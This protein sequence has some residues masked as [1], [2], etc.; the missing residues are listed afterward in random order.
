M[1]LMILIVNK[2][3]SRRRTKTLVI[4]FFRS[5]MN[6]QNRIV[7]RI[8][9]IYAGNFALKTLY[10]EIRGTNNK[11]LCNYFLELVLSNASFKPFANFSGLSTA[12]K[13]IMNSLGLSNSMWL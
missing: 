8:I 4:I 5:V 7:K 6:L 3:I 12:Q 1:C 9:Q 13:C 11:Q 10:Q 2:T